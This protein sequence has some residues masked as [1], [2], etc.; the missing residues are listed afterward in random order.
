MQSNFAT[1]KYCDELMLDNFELTTYTSQNSQ[2][3]SVPDL[4]VVTV[5]FLALKKLVF[6][7]FRT[8]KKFQNFFL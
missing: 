2:Q 4:F 8:Q 7:I 5:A 1:E 3:K 6:S